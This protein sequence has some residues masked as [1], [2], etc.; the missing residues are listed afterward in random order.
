[1]A[2]QVF[3][4]Y[5]ILTIERVISSSQCIKCLFF[6]QL[7]GVFFLASGNVRYVLT[8]GTYS[9]RLWESVFKHSEKFHLSF[10]TMRLGHLNIDLVWEYK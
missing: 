8:H 6:F 7:L 1:M 3:I 2:A 9:Y 4:N 10:L 5:Y